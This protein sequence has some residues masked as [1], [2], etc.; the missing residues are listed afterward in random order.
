MCCHH[1]GNTAIDFFFLG[2]TTITTTLPP[3]TFAFSVG[4]KRPLLLS[5]RSWCS[6]ASRE[7][8]GVRCWSRR[9]FPVWTI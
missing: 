9:W 8:S 3:S 4:R 6:E 7:V 5:G 1:H 2:Y